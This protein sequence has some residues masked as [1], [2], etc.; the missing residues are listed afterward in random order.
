M[1]QAVREPVAKKGPRV[2]MFVTLPGRNIVFLPHEAHIGVS[3]MIDDPAERRRLHAKLQELLEPGSGAIVR[4]V[5]EGATDHELQEDVRILRTQWL[6]ICQRFEC[7]SGPSFLF[8]DFDLMLRALRDLA[9]A[10]TE[11]VWI[12]NAEQVDRAEAFL[13]RFHPGKRPVARLY[14]GQSPLFAKHGVDRWIH[15]A[16]SPTVPLKSGGQLVI[17][18]T[19]AMTVIDINSERQIASEKLENAVLKLN[20][21][22]AREIALQLRL[23]N[24]GGLVVVDFVDMPRAEDQRMLE[25][26]FEIE[27]RIDRARVHMGPLSRFGVIE[28]SRKRLRESIYDRLTESCPTC[29]G[30]GYIR[31]ASDLAIEVLARI[32]RAAADERTEKT[33]LRVEV[34]V[35]V[36]AVLRGQLA[37]VLLDVTKGTHIEI[38]LIDVTS[39]HSHEADIRLVR[40]PAG[41][42]PQD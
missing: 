41:S 39:S 35:R 16:T 32:R 33:T 7:S 3:R 19:E 6:D 15:E 31:S 37:D 11:T 17:D 40:A 34:P 26:V 8:A 1:V 12:D 38:E 10:E 42:S 29:A 27:L 4:T 36:G 13:A 14:E 21:E 2:T 28:L 20:L 5:G 18:R 9:S 30:A 23:R 24:I 22:A 25:A